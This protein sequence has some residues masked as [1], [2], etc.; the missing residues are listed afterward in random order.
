MN[1]SY[2]IEWNNFYYCC[3]Q[4]QHWNH[5]ILPLFSRELA[6]FRLFRIFDL[7]GQFYQVI[8]DV[9]DFWQLFGDVLQLSHFF[10]VNENWRRSLLHWRAE[11]VN[12]CGGEA[13]FENW[14]KEHIQ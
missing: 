12:K 7:I 10:V 8:Y 2:Q 13:D 5:H 6:H 14:H 3:Y 11:Q 4:S 9:I 1:H